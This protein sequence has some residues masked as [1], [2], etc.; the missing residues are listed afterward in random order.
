MSYLNC[1][2]DIGQRFLFSP[3]SQFLFFLLVSRFSAQPLLYLLCFSRFFPVKALLSLV[4]ISLLNTWPFTFYGFVSLGPTSPNS[5]SLSLYLWFFCVGFWLVCWFA[6]T[7]TKREKNW[8]PCRNQCVVVCGLPP[9]KNN[10]REQRD[11][12]QG[13]R[14]QQKN[15]KSKTKTP[16]K[17]PKKVRFGGC[18]KPSQWLPPHNLE[19][20]RKTSFRKG[21]GEEEQKRKT[22]LKDWSNSYPRGWKGDKTWVWNEGS[23]GKTN[24]CK[25][26]GAQKEN[27]KNEENWSA[28]MGKDKVKTLWCKDIIFIFGNFENLG[29]NFA[30]WEFWGMFKN[31]IFLCT[32]LWLQP[33]SCWETFSNFSV[34]KPL[35][36]S[37]GGG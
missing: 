14:E 3:F 2:N 5:L 20:R 6:T 33:G 8:W 15:E 25:K 34:M 17:S 9:Q 24:S 7:T 31:L 23:E 4:S 1:L 27:K 11:E 29:Q 36:V 12:K 19:Q 22:K 26:G 28:E 37:A 18:A 16:K 35:K 10:K 32:S 21:G 13:T 30:K